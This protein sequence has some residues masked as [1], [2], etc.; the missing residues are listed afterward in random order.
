MRSILTEMMY[1]A[2]RIGDIDSCNKIH[3]LM[4]NGVYAMNEY[5]KFAKKEPLLHL[6]MSSNYVNN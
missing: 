3:T 5:M 2:V 4:Y 1:H 6:G